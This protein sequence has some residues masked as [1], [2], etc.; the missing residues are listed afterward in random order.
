MRV[1]IY[2]FLGWWWKLFGV[3][4][5][6]QLLLQIPVE[7]KPVWYF[8]VTSSRQLISHKNIKFQATSKIFRQSVK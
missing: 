5:S 7:I 1:R 3:I 6:E 2:L 4:F 8:L